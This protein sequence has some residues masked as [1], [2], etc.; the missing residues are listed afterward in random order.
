[1]RNIL[2]PL[3]LFFISI[4]SNAGYAQNVYVQQQVPVYQPILQYPPVQVMQ[5]QTQYYTVTIPYVQYYPAVEQRIVWYPYQPVFNP[6]YVY[7]EKR[8]RLLP[9]YRY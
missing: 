4:L 3:V 1:M 8:C 2:I 5:Y 6:V 7:P 9:N